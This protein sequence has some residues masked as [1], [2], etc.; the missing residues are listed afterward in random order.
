MAAARLVKYWKKRLEICDG[1]TDKAFLPFTQNGLIKDDGIVLSLG[2]MRV[3][4]QRDPSGRTILFFDPSR[5]DRSRYTRHS[6]L[7]AVWYL[8][9]VALTTNETTQNKGVVFMAFPKNAKMGQ[10]DRTQSNMMIASIRGCLPIRV[11]VFHICHPPTFFAVLFNIVKVF[12]GE[13]LRKR[14]K[15]HAGKHVLSKLA[16]FGLTA[17]LLPTELGGQVKLNHE[18]FLKERREL[19]ENM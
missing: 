14:V 12:L 6:F 19:E 18:A 10:F 8:I 7:R 2:I 9:H 4:P 13:L 15:V 16:A 11:S 5:Q 3:L 17:D 1:D